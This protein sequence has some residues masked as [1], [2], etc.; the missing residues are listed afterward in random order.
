MTRYWKWATAAVL[1]CGSGY[2]QPAAIEL[3]R[4]SIVIAGRSGERSVLLGRRNLFAGTDSVFLRGRLMARDQEYAINYRSGEVYF[5]VPL[6][7]A[8]TAIALFRALS[9][10]VPESLVYLP[11]GGADTFAAEAGSASRN[12]YAAASASA[13]VVP[14]TPPLVRFGGSKTFTIAA[15]TGRDLSLEQSLNVS[16]IGRLSPGL[17]ISALL[18][19]KNLPLSTAGSTEE[20]SQLDQMYI[21]ARADRWSATLGDLDL[22][23]PSM[24]LLQF[25]RQ[26]EG[27]HAAGRL[28][29]AEAGV[30]YSISKGKPGTVR[31][32]G[33][34]GKQGPYILTAEDGSA[35][36]RVLANS[37]KVWLDGELLRP[38]AAA[39]YTVD[40]D[41]AQLTFTPRRPIRS[42]SRIVVQFQYS[43]QNYQRSLYFVDARVPLSSQADLR[44]AFYQEYD[45]D[46]IFSGEALS[47]SQRTALGRAGNDTAKLW[48]DGGTRVDSGTGSYVR[49]DSIYVYEP[50]GAGDYAVSF[51][52]TGAGGG[53]YVYDSVLGGFRYV[54]AGLGNYAAK[55]R[56]IS[57]RSHRVMNLRSEFV[58]NGGRSH[59]EGSYSDLD[60]NTLSAIDDGR[61]TGQAGTAVFAWKR[62]SLPWGG[63]EIRSSWTSV[64]AT[65]R[66][67]EVERMPDFEAQWGLNNWRELSPIDPAG[68]RQTTD[69]YAAY[70]LLNR[71]TFGG[72]WGRLGIPGGLW[73]RKYLLKSA[74]TAPGWPRVQYGY[75]RY[76]VG[77]AWQGRPGTTGRRDLH[78]AR[79]QWQRGAWGIDAGFTRN[80]DLLEQGTAGASGS[81]YW[82]AL[83]GWNRSAGG[84]E[85]GQTLQRRD[86]SRRDSLAPSWAGQ[87]FSNTVTSRAGLHRADRLNITAD[88]T[89]RQV[90]LR[91]GAA[92]NAVNSNL[93]GFHADHA[94][95]D[96]QLRLTFDY[97]L[98]SAETALQQELYVR[99][100]D[101]TGEYGYDPATG[102]FF[103]DTA[104]NYRRTVSDRGG[105]LMTAENSAKA[106]VSLAPGRASGWWKDSRLDL[107][108]AAAISSPEA[109]DLK[110]LTFQHDQ[111]W[112]PT[113]LQSNF[114]LTA[115]LFHS[116][117]AGWNAR[118]HLRWRREA[119]S[120][121][122]GRHAETRQVE[123]RSDFFLPLPSSGRLSLFAENNTVV[124]SSL[125]AGRE[126]GSEAIKAGGDCGWQFGRDFEL[127]LRTDAGREW[128]ERVSGIPQALHVKYDRL[129][130]IPYLTYQLG[131]SGRARA[132][133]GMVRLAS[134]RARAEI[135]LE[136]AL[137]RPLGLT[138]TWSLQYDY[139][140]N[141]NLTSSA[142]YDGR[143]EPDTRPSHTARFDL[144]AYF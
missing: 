127:A 68:P 10:V 103:P 116:S 135:P 48:V 50:A 11:A 2:P 71:V 111:L 78:Q 100:P 31:F 79:S 54:G 6:D 52:A 32:P 126:S 58:W 46:A 96:G 17:E 4:D 141:A 5:S 115:D 142:G 45:D 61:N 38:G 105:T 56:L 70:T 94:R 44:A 122:G 18:S 8:D 55:R 140:L 65:Y 72:G 15:G 97:I 30:T 36:Y 93:A 99:V 130:V 66:N 9:V 42:D 108:A 128:L 39:D 120:R 67:S 33:Q 104:G 143:K 37:Q 95:Q 85:I 88:H 3:M 119:D 134:D 13:A 118:G 144:R 132:E 138:K 40:Y 136:F 82:E 81:R 19:D 131:L 24:S 25:N 139:R 101:R 133:I 41:R 28:N 123:R 12:G 112:R 26:L 106:F 59:L 124:V 117:P 49:I 107:L 1:V 22:T 77:D 63:F 109:I 20:A 60:R 86:D 21:Q 14:E 83:M 74:L 35:D 98:S 64:G 114:D 80:L 62:D 113:N 76:L 47:D 43:S 129:A 27:V 69:L 91:A 110:T 51:T 137:T 102:Q 87:S 73:D 57:P 29:G 92:G 84:W 53:D 23:Y 125:E 121:F 16:A 89:F 90:R 34:D 75:S 7:P